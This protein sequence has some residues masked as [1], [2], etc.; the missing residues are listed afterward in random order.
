MTGYVVVAVVAIVANAV[1]V[2]ADPCRR[3]L[4][5]VSA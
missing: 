1:V 2:V 3:A 4:L 5:E